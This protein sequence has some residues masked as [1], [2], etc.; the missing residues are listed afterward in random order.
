VRFDT[1][2]CGFF[3]A[4]RVGSVLATVAVLATPAAAQLDPLLPLKRVPPTILIVVDTSFRMLDDGTGDY[5]DPTTYTRA[6]DLPVAAALNVPATAPTYRRVYHNLQ[7]ETTQSASQ[8]YI[9]DDVVAVPSTA[10]AYATFW[11]A[12]RIEIAKRGIAT[13]VGQNVGSRYRWG[14][15]KLRQT[16]PSWVAS[17]NCDKPVRVTSNPALSGVADL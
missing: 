2:S 7:F 6:N 17:P 12:T 13:A 5:Y 10:A 8:K 14:L 4:A 16:S 1:P 9:A 15:M 3:R 11:D